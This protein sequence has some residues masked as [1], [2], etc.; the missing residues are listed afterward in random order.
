MSLNREEARFPLVDWM[1][2]VAIL[3]H[4][5]TLTKACDRVVVMGGATGDVVAGLER[6][7]AVGLAYGVGFAGEEDAGADYSFVHGE[8]MEAASE[9]AVRQPGAP[10][11]LA[12]VSL[13]QQKKVTVLGSQG[14]TLVESLYHYQ[15]P[16]TVDHLQPLP[17][18]K[19]MW[20]LLSQ[21]FSN[22]SSIG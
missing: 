17:S 20:M 18:L 5:L 9:V 16:L 21:C 14:T 7:E 2:G 15:H 8:R 1:L 6:V 3:G 22:A 13:V 10:W 19:G 11:F 4:A 12:I